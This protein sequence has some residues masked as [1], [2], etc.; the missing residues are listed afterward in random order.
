MNNDEYDKLSLS[1]RKKEDWLNTKWRPAMG[2]LYL[3][4]C[5]FD[6]VIFPIFWSVIQALGK[7]QVNI[8]WQPITLFGAGLFHLSMGAILGIAVYGRTQEKI[9]GVAGTIQLP[10]NV[11]STYVPPP[12]PSSNFGQ[13]VQTTVVQSYG[14]PLSRQEKRFI[15]DQPLPGFRGKLRPPSANQPEI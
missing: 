14:S 6:F 10:Q 11:G 13:P 9:N 5:I 1:E 7:G 2:W 12:P 8:Q 4:V 15:D 3:I